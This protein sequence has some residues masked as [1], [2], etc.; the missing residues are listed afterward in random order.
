MNHTEKQPIRHVEYL[1]H[2]TACQ[3]DSIAWRGRCWSWV[4]LSTWSIRIYPPYWNQHQHSLS[5][6]QQSYRLN[7]RARISL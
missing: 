1:S 2:K 3:A 6:Y 4:G 7:F 5:P